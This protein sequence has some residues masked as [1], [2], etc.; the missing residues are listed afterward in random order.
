MITNIYR[1]LWVKVLYDTV[2]AKVIFWVRAHF[3]F[4]RWF[5]SYFSYLFMT[6]TFI[7]INLYS[8]IYSW[9]SHIFK[10]VYKPLPSQI[11]LLRSFNLFM[12]LLWIMAPAIKLSYT[13]VLQRSQ[14][15]T[16][17]IQFKLKYIVKNVLI[18]Y[19]N[20]FMMHDS[21]TVMLKH[22]VL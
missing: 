14:S 18:Q 10:Y 16:E 19:I 7:Y 15:K 22:F 1:S 3:F 5:I 21:L 2:C 13:Y 17:K 9:Q 20:V 8:L 11:F 4:S 12:H 6:I